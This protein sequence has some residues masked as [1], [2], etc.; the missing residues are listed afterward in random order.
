MTTEE[1]R[2]RFVLRRTASAR[3]GSV[4]ATELRVLLLS[5]WGASG[6]YS[7]PLTFMNRMWSEIT[8]RHPNV[9]V[10]L[11][12]RDRGQDRA[13]EWAH[14]I[15]PAVRSEEFGRVAQ[16]RWMFAAA[17]WVIRYRRSADVIH[18]QGTYLTNLFPSLFARRGS[19]V[20]LPVLEDGDLGGLQRASAK[21]WIARRVGTRARSGFALSGGIARELERAGLEAHRVGRLSNPVDPRMIAEAPSS[22]DPEGP[23]RLGFVGKLGPLKNPHLLVEASAAL[24]DIGRASEVHF[25]GPFASLAMEQRLRGIAADLKVEDQIH[26]HGFQNEILPAFDSFDI[27]VLPSEQEGLPGSL[28][29]AFAM[30]KPVIVTDVGSMAEYVHRAGAG[31][32][33]RA[34]TDEIVD[35]VLSFDRGDTWTTA[36]RSARAFASE[37]L[38]PKVVAD[39]YL[40]QIERTPR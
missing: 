12:H 22:P 39:Q 14:E 13:P 33:V 4:G 29:E 10:T 11:L 2:G 3:S 15:I 23:V 6:G 26:F 1:V 19:V 32:V 24:R 25:F 31:R 9:R 17:F 5:P 30:G 7:G 8:A 35:A 18:L 28:M 20:M 37:H 27:L 34:R 16:V 21:R 36:S 38:D 40:H